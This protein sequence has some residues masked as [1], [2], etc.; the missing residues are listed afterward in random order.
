MKD[1]H[2]PSYS[3]VTSSLPSIMAF[4]SKDLLLSQ[5]YQQS[6]PYPEA[7]DAHRDS[8]A[9]LKQV[10]EDSLQNYFKSLANRIVLRFQQR[11]SNE[12]HPMFGFDPCAFHYYRYSQQKFL[13]S[14][15]KD[16]VGS[17]DDAE[18]YYKDRF[19]AAFPGF[20]I[21][22]RRRSHESYAYNVVI[23]IPESE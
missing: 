10:H 21:Q 17:P 8:L 19:A 3:C 16:I 15:L 7:Q 11:K 12:P 1:R 13:S 22:I 14:C 23:E 18:A 20:A 4:L 5:H 2:S 6:L 9:Y